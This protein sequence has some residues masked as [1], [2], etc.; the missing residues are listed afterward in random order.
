MVHTGRMSTA[1]VVIIVIVVVVIAL[2]AFAIAQFNRLRR[3]DLLSQGAL[4]DIDTL[5]TKRADLV[6]S[7]VATVEGARDFEA[8]TMAAVSEAR[9]RTVGATSVDERSAAD[10]DLTGA[11]GRLFAVAE[12]YPTLTAA[13]NFRD[14]Q[15]QLGQLE[16]QLQFARQFYNDATVTLNTA[17]RVIPSMWFAGIAGV[18]PRDLYREPDNAKRSAP[19]VS[20]D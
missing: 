17:L 2:A 5:L 8:S 19:G 11:L 14:L 7:L 10:A 16:G 6:P 18:S 12:A 20:F 4:A 15:G 13:A 3:L 1:I 9:A